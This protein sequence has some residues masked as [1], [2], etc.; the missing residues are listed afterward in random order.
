MP[1][2]KRAIRPIARFRPRSDRSLPAS[3]ALGRL[4]IR[5]S[6]ESPYAPNHI[7]GRDAVRGGGLIGLERSCQLMLMSVDDWTGGVIAAR[8]YDAS[9]SRLIQRIMSGIG[10]LDAGG[11]SRMVFRSGG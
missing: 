4:R 6:M 10:F 5:N 11:S 3:A 2:R 7:R 8:P 9:A 1:K